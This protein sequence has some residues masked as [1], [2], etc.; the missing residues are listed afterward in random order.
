MKSGFHFFLVAIL[1]VHFGACQNDHEILDALDVTEKESSTVIKDVESDQGTEENFIKK[2]HADLATKNDFEG[3]PAEKEVIQSVSDHELNAQESDSS[4]G[5]L[6]NGVPEPSN[7]FKALP[8]AIFDGKSHAKSHL[9]KTIRKYDK[10]EF[11]KYSEPIESDSDVAAD[12]S[13]QYGR[14]SN[15]NTFEIHPSYNSGKVYGN[16]CYDRVKYVTKYKV[17]RQQVS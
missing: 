5:N 15:Q 14:P 8:I 13:G 17:R 10:F 1:L 12:N 16:R 7:I 4:P 6:Y 3:T 2:S 9:P 11:P